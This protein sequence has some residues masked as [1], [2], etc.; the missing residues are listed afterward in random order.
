MCAHVGAKLC[1]RV[2]CFPSYKPLCFVGVVV[3]VLIILFV[4]SCAQG[5][6]SMCIF[7]PVSDLRRWICIINW[8]VRSLRTHTKCFLKRSV[9]L[10][11][12]PL[13]QQQPFPKDDC[14]EENVVP[15]GVDAAIM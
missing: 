6:I 3:I 11:G 15:G 8:L 5:H 4:K 13:S 2:G 1:V 14:C 9:N 10:S 12:A 7:S